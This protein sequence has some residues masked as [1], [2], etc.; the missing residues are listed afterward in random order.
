MIE[1]PKGSSREAI[2]KLILD[3]LEE[4]FDIKD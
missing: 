1:Y 4:K 3:K 2:E